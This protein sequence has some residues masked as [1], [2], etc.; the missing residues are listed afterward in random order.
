MGTRSSEAGRTFRN[1]ETLVIVGAALVGSV[2]A[3]HL[4][5]FERFCEWARHHE[6]LQADELLIA[7]MIFCLAFFSLFMRRDSDLRRH[8]ATTEAARETA[9]WAAHQDE[10]TGLPNRRAFMEHG[11]RAQREGKEFSLLILDLDNFKAINDTWGHAAGDEVL[12]F[13]AMQLKTLAGKMPGAFTA[14]LGGDEFAVIIEQDPSTERARHFAE[15]VIEAMA[16]PLSN[17]QD[18]K[19]GA[20]VGIALH[21]RGATLGNS[22]R[23]ADRSMYRAKQAGGSCFR[24]APCND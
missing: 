18:C 22:L 15:S 17:W 23:I 4:Q 9:F 12:C 6:H 16:S 20:S 11:T 3:A 2:L 7:A 5:A 21:V 24:R 14:R 13:A 8:L 1:I 19:L 10:L